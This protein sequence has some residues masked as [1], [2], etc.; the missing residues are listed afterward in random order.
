[1]K[2]AGSARPAK[3]PRD[4]SFN[5]VLGLDCITFH[6]INEKKYTALSA[7]CEG[8]TYQVVALLEDT[9]SAAIRDALARS[10][11]NW[12]G[13]P[14]AVHVDMGGGFMK[15]FADAVQAWGSRCSLVAGQAPWQHGVAERHGGW[16]KEIWKKLVEEAN[17]DGIEE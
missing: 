2:K 14:D 13:P 11:V 10:W 12:A 9:S 16:W 8:T 1:M 3:L 4:C 7:V 17:V 5:T 15:D 6:D